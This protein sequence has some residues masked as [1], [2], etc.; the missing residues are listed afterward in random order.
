M[1]GFGRQAVLITL[2]V[3]L[4][5]VF[6]GAIE[7]QWSGAPSRAAIESHAATPGHPVILE[8]VKRIEGELRTDILRLEAKID[9]LLQH[10]GGLE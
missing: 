6:G 1:N 4:G 7:R 3:I 8:R 5:A 9:R 10:Q 2:S